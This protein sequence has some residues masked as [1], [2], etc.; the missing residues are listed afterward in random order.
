I[1]LFKMESGSYSFKLS[2]PEWSEERDLAISQEQDSLVTTDVLY[3]LQR[4]YGEFEN[5]NMD[6]DVDG[7]DQTFKFSLDASS[8]INNP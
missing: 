2:D 7:Q 1:A 3:E 4:K 6:I 8:G 5:Q